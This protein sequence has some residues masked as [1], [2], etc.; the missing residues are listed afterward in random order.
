MDDLTKETVAKVLQLPLEVNAE[1]ERQ[2]IN[3]FASR[4]SKMTQN[5]Y[6]QAL[7]PR[8]AKLITNDY[9]TAPG[10]WLEHRDK[11]IV[12]LPG[13]PREL[14]PMFI[15]K[16]MPL[17]PS[18]GSSLVSRT[19]KV[20]GLGESSVEDKLAE[21]IAAQTNPTIAPL[22]KLG[23][24]HLRLTAKARSRTECQ[25]LL[26]ET[27]AKL[28]A[29]LGNAIYARDEQTMGSVVAELLS[30]NKLSLAL[31]ESCTG[32]YLAHTLTN[33]PGSS[34]FFSAGLVTYSNEAKSKLLGI[35]LQFIEE[36]DAVSAEVG[37]AMAS[38]VREVAESDLGMGITGIAGPTG[39]TADKPVGLVYI[40]LATPTTVTCQRFNFFG[41]R[42]NIK[43]RAVMS[44]LNMLRLY[45][46]Q[47]G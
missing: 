6:K 13:P 40:A 11:I 42:E 14:E 4:G 39:G 38:Q 12:L 7:L 17:L 26:D 43:E 3:M 5:N 22:A 29:R 47:L 33:I 10:I 41:K 45:L 20:V 21:I 16:I 46:I 23:E 19:L 37:R 35:P 9:G 24:V 27:E 31:A 32:G 2:L 36:H 34:S 44:A 30:K 25:E 18:S 1:W 8:G 15:E 28:T